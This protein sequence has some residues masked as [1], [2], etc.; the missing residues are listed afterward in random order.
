MRCREAPSGIRSGAAPPS[1]SSRGGSRRC[2]AG[3]GAAR[4]RRGKCAT[5][6]G[7][8]RGGVRRLAASNT[9]RNRSETVR[10]RNTTWLAARGGGIVGCED[11]LAFALSLIDR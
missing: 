10:Q 7:G 1:G 3:G 5:H 6:R 11:D 8:E 2:G 4:G 9:N